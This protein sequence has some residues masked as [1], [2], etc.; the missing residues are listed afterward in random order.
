MGG[1][2][3]AP[4]HP[5]ILQICVI[6]LLFSENFYQRFDL[7][8]DQDMQR[9]WQTGV[10]YVINTFHST[11]FDIPMRPVREHQ[12]HRRRFTRYRRPATPM[13]VTIPL[14]FARC[15]LPMHRNRQVKSSL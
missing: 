1:G 7:D 8:N 4:P 6:E 14:N 9:T 5:F 10:A 13:I 2:H 15:M 3:P 12:R 11:I